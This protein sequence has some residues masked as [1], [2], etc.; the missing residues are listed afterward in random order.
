MRDE[1][2]CK[3]IRGGPS[4]LEQPAPR[5]PPRVSHGHAGSAD[6]TPS[7]LLLCILFYPLL[8][9]LQMFPLS[10]SPWSLST[11]LPPHPR[12]SPPLL[13]MLFPLN[14]WV[15]PSQT[16]LDSD[17]N[18]HFLCKRL[19]CR[20]CLRVSPFWPGAR[21]PAVLIL[22]NTRLPVL[23]VAGRK[24]E[25]GPQ[26]TWPPTSAPLCNCSSGFILPVCHLCFNPQ[27]DGQALLS[28]R[29]PHTAQEISPE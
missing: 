12:P 4:N 29:R 13:T 24:L 7:F 3:K 9:A 26:E 2:G 5:C 1:W 6:N 14:R 10:P 15:A 23:Q 11:P 21:R 18:V 8:A 16:F 28:E 19:C 25:N 27:R 22:G 17:P 20:C